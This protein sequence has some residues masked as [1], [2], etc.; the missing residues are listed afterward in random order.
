MCV[1]GCGPSSGVR[2]S[3]CV[4][5][6]VLALGIGAT[7]AIF[8]LVDAIILSPLPFA[9]AE[10]LVDLSHSAP[11]VGR[12]NVGTCA[13]WHYT[14]E[15]E[16]RVFDR[17]AMFTTSTATITGGTEPEA[18]QS[19][20]TTADLFNVLGM[21]PHLGRVFGRDD[22]KPGA[23]AVVLLS[24]GYWASRFGGRS[25]VVGKTLQVDGQPRIIVGVLP[26]TLR[27][28]GADPAIVRPL[29]F[30]RANLF[31]GNVGNTGI[32]RLKRG[33]TREQAAGDMARMLPMAFEKFPGGPVIEAARQANYIP[34]VR[35]FKD[36]LVGDARTLLWTLMAGVSVVLFIA[37][38]N[39]ANLFLVRAEGKD[40]EMAV[41]AAIGA[42]PWRLSWEY[43]KESLLLGV[44]GGSA[45]VA[46]AWAG[47]KALVA[48]APPQLP[49]LDQVTLD[50][51]A[52]LF[53]AA[54]SVGAALVFATL[55][56]LRRWRRDV[57]ESLK[58]GGH[59]AGV[60][61]HR[62]R[63]Q[64][65]L[66]AS[67]VAFALVLLVASGLMLRS[68]Q[69][70]GGVDRGFVHADDV[71][72]L[73]VTIGQRTVR[74]TEEAALVQESIARRL[75]EV[76]GVR[77]VGMA[78]ALPMHRGG[79]I[80]PLYVEGVTVQ[81][82]TPPITRRHKWIGP[83]YFE[84]L[85]IPLR[86]GRDYTWQDVHN[87][88]PGVIV[89]ESLAR[90]YWGSVDAAIGKRVSVRPDP[91]RWHEV[92]GV[93][94]DVRDDGVSVEPVPM[95]YWPQVTLAFWQGDRADEMLV[96]GA[97]SYAVRSDRVGTPGFLEDVRRAVWSVN[98]DLPLQAVGP[99]SEFVARTTA[100]TSFTLAL[101][102]IA[103][104]V[105]LILGLVGV[106]GVISYGVS[107]RT[108]E[109][110][111]R[112]ALGANAGRILRLVLFQGLAIIVAGLVVGL[113]LALLVTR[114]MA[115]LLF[116]VGPADP[117]TFALV[118]GLLMVVALAASYLPARRAARVAPMVVLR[119]E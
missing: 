118:A 25:D 39:V 13:A 69:A 75:G 37:C 10:R 101:L 15:D 105:A 50:S 87:R 21:G 53:A 54:L 66:A 85:G 112:M 33:V 23:E 24:H 40:R 51:R 103:A 9:D 27:A 102:G 78:T 46:L 82:R 38:A 60:G 100:R 81:G 28:L 56:A 59:A 32:A 119:A 47:L 30:N 106:Y 67:Q 45:G 117:L 1:S 2:P 113:G 29:R 72:A 116:G 110:G 97:V 26:P 73:R 43:L 98:R 92:I 8:T 114:A 65:L 35:P 44:L 12:G 19:L 7:T 83:G 79:N 6:F 57:V 48:T 91:V 70:L 86:V 104:I 52:L 49:S 41:R 94:G 16:N 64:N 14:Y 11:N 77:S 42:G 17:L 68:A 109:L 3:A 71:L 107:L 90:A 5:V 111:M 63:L 89:S 58:Q 20:A 76:A 74:S 108:L 88:I 80:N 84:T 34:S 36:V 95:V 99:M 4:V 18:V 93:A 115:G 22:E 62:H 61:R 31:V 96:W 55:P